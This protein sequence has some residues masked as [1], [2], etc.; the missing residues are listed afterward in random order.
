MVRR[1]GWVL[2]LIALAIP[3]TA[4]P[5][6]GTLAGTVRNL[7]GEPQMGAVVE[8]LTSGARSLI[9]YTNGEG[10]YIARN[11]VPGTYALKVTAPSFL[12]AVRQNIQ[13][14]TGMGV[15]V[16]VTLTTLFEA[17][18]LFPPKAGTGDTESEWKWTLRSVGNRPVL[19]FLDPHTLAVVAD[20]RSEGD[21]ALTAKLAFM[22]G[23]DGDGF[24]G[25][26]A[27]VTTN[28]AVE[29]S[30]FSTGRL[31]IDGNIGYSGAGTPTGIMRASYRHTLADGSTPE[32]AFTIRRLATS[33]TADRLAALQALSLSVS[34]RKTI[35]NFLELNYGGQLDTVQFQ[36]RV[37]ALRPFGSVDVH[38][39]PDMVLEYLYATSEPTM[40]GTK[41]FETAPADLSES[42]PRMSMMGGE[43][44]L[45]RAHHHEL[46]ISR[47]VGKNRFQLAAFRDDIADAA[48]TG[49]GLVRPDSGNFLPDV[50]AGTF[51]Y[52]GG[53]LRT[54]G[55]RVVAE[56]SFTSSLT[57]TVVYSY[58][59][60]RTLAQTGV[61]L[62]AAQFI[63]ERRHA[64]A[65]KV[66]GRAPHSHTHWLASYRWTSGPAITPVDLFD[67]SPGQADPYLS[68]YLS[69]PLPALSFL[70]GQVEALVDVRNL[71]AQ[72]YLPVL[73]QDGSTAYLVQAPRSLRAGVAFTF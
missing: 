67:Q 26:T 52:N 3:A 41:G 47:R 12:P 61:P 58:G 46:S 5:Q 49:M 72:G 13:L 45:E 55:F 10:R 56:R 43:P 20:S 69:Q 9:V 1:L 44:V 11:L 8:V 6:P 59:G 21:R 70:P 64:V 30:L 23:S 60:A 66:L 38:L 51:T 48:L 40:R 50:Y 7:A 19:R 32:V 24:G 54:D 28:F 33:T 18:Q 42:T 14:R 25:A 35:L 68:I 22:A 71:L 73:A 2:F 62:E 16:D 17:L 27:G 57:G 29:Q 39:S 31:A 36:E 53:D 4:V 15:V 37:T 65:V 63:T 34:D